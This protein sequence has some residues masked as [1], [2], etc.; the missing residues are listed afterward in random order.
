[1]NILRSN[2]RQYIFALTEVGLRGGD[3]TVKAVTYWSLYMLRFYTE[4]QFVDV[5]A[6]SQH[7]VVQTY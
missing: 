5:S 4:V 3:L 6:R 2:G 1:M 7:L